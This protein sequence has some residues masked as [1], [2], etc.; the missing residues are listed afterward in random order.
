MW[1]S[2]DGSR[3]FFMDDASA[4]LTSNTV[5]G[6]GENLYEYNVETADLTDLTPTAGPAVLG[7]SGISEDGDYVYFIA[8]GELTNQENGEKAKAEAGQPN[9]YLWHA[10][11]TTYIA[12]LAGFDHSCEAPNNSEKPCGGDWLD[13]ELKELTARVSPN[14]QFIGFNSVKSLTGYNNIPVQPGECR[15]EEGET[16]ACQEIFLYSA[17]QNQLSC[18]SCAP[19]GARPIAPAGIYVSDH[20]WG[21]GAAPIRTPGYLQRNVLN[22]GLV[23]FTTREP[24]VATDTNGKYDA[25]EYEEGQLHPLSTTTSNVNSFFY[26]TD[27][28]GNNVFV[29]TAMQ[30]PSGKPEAVYSIYDARVDGGFQEPA[31]LTE[32]S[33]EDCKGSFSPPPAIS[34]PTSAT[35]VGAGN[36]VLTPA[37][38][39]KATTTAKKKKKKKRHKKLGSRRGA[40]RARNVKGQSGAKIEKRARTKR[41]AALNRGGK[42]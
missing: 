3:V 1:A 13:W 14:G 27:L 20:D 42:K 41:A 28:A 10:G 38:V 11:T 32:C 26:E 40:G 23:F 4:G 36:P 12:T 5:P 33:E 21:G 7:V 16:E 35:F 6:S 25:Y 15:G 24:L 8:E 34:A 2:T 37:V 31:N 39:H 22:N 18:V 30:L 17:G 29:I 19:N 9:L